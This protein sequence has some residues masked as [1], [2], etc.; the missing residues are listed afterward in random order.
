MGREVEGAMNREKKLITFFIVAVLIAVAA[1]FIGYKV[2][3][4]SKV[5]TGD[6]KKVDKIMS[7]E[8]S[9]HR[10]NT[11]NNL[12]NKGYVAKQG[13]W[14]YYR[15]ISDNGCIYKM[16][17]KGSNK[18]KL[19]KNL[20]SYINVVGEWV[21]YITD[22]GIF[23]VKTDGSEEKKIRDIKDDNELLINTLPRITDSVLMNLLK[24]DLQ[25]LI[26]GS[27]KVYV[28]NLNVI[29]DKVYYRVSLDSHFNGFLIEMNNEGKVKRTLQ[30]D[31][32]SWNMAIDE[33]FIYYWERIL[34]RNKGPA[35]KMC[36]D[37]SAKTEL[38]KKNENSAYELERISG[39]TFNGT[40]IYFN[41]IESPKTLCLKQDKNGNITKFNVFNEDEKGVADPMNAENGFI[42]YSSI[43]GV[44]KIKN[45][46]SNRVKLYDKATNNIFIA[47]EWMYFTERDDAGKEQ[48]LCRMKLD[49][50]NQEDVN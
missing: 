29:G 15:N 30:L 13:E 48:K 35:Y 26:D 6:I 20:G 49:G 38:I 43:G 1:G 37:G 39:I 34:S 27:G 31:V 33:K 11:M 32:A 28:N 4:P 14:I 42:Y 16:K 45:D 36:L 23:K 24:Q 3:K 44:F 18:V 5:T 41:S 7:E 25:L 22:E 2:M 9:N 8:K 40:D 21:Y 46:G 12:S 47:G 50:T 17:E 19:T 10:G